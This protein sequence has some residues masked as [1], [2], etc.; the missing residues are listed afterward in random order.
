MAVDPGEMSAPMAVTDQDTAPRPVRVQVQVHERPDPASILSIAVDETG[1]QT[2]TVPL[3]E[4]P[5]KEDGP[6]RTEEAPLLVSVRTR[7][8]CWPT[9]A[10]NRDASSLADIRGTG[11]GGNALPVA[12]FLRAAGGFTAGGFTAGGFTAGGFTAGD[13]AAG[14][15]VA[16]PGAPAPGA[17]RVPA[18]VVAVWGT[19]IAFTG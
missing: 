9:V 8:T 16:G 3:P 14:N 19:D 4:A 6:A 2:E 1:R 18:G 10:R 12:A 5:G 13:F 11:R 15:K 17:S 7:V